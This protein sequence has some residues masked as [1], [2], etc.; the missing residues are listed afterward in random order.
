MVGTGKVNPLPARSVAWRARRE[1]SPLLAELVSCLASTERISPLLVELVS[2]SISQFGG[3]SQSICQFGGVIW[4]PGAINPVPM[5][6][7]TM[8]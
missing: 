4:A 6:L 3:I 1:V 2:Q 8:A 7:P 5:W